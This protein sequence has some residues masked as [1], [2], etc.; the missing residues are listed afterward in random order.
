MLHAA[1]TTAKGAVDHTITVCCCYHFGLLIHYHC[2]LLPCCA[3][4]PVLFQLC[5]HRH[6]S[7]A[8]DSTDFII[9]VCCCS[10][11]LSILSCTIHT[12]AKG[13]IDHTIT[14]CCCHAVQN[15][16]LCFICMIIISII[17]LLP[18]V[19]WTTSSLYAAA[20]LYQTPCVPLFLAVLNWPA[21]LCC[22]WLQLQL[23]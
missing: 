13:S 9:A 11:V 10:A 5:Y 1:L 22:G 21:V 20:F 4:H 2:V 3:R 19:P 23:L 16:L 6:H 18:R 7:A 8:K 12:A 17:I 14:V 15:I